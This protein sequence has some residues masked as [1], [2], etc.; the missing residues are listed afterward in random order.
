ML[1]ISITQ[2]QEKEHYI[3]FNAGTGLQNLKYKLDNGELDK[4]LG[5]TFNFGYNYFFNENWGVVSG[6]GIQSFRSEAKLNYMTETP[7]VDSDGESYF[8]RVYYTNW[9]EKQKILF[10]D[11]P[12][13]AAYK[14][15]LNEQWKLQGSL[16]LKISLPLRSKY[17]ITDGEIETRGYYPQYNVEL[18]GLPQHNLITLNSVPS[19]HF[20]IKPLYSTFIDI[21]A[22][23]NFGKVFDIYMGA[24]FNY[25][26]NNSIDENTN[27]LYQE[28]GTY[29]G[30]LGS[31]LADKLH[32]MSIGIKVGISLPYS[33][34][35]TIISKKNTN[36]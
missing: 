31:N 28:N 33:A 11:I 19:D 12:V 20:S 29:S 23:Y 7:S 8:Y 26:L 13:G 5:Y 4:S 15:K 2:A 14:R 17:E 24:Y 1:G 6:I 18:Y 35:K 32:P 25:A 22:F 3:S 30:V 34:I 16:G 21:G 36:D 27:L 10:F 9:T